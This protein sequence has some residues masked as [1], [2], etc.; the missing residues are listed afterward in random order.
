MVKMICDEQSHRDL[1][2][3][4]DLGSIICLSCGELLAIYQ[5]LRAED[6]IRIL[7]L[8]PGKENSELIAE[9]TNIQLK[10][11]P[12]FNAVSY[13]WADRHGDVSLSRPFSILKSGMKQ[14]LWVTKNCEAALRRFRDL[15]STVYLWIDSICIDQTNVQERSKQVMLMTKIY[16]SA[17]RVLVYLGDGIE[18]A[19]DTLSYCEADA[20]IVKLFDYLRG[21]CCD[22]GLFLCNEAQNYPSTCRTLESLL[23]DEPSHPKSIVRDVKKLLSIR[24]FSRVWI[25]Q[26]IV[27]AREAIIFCGGHSIDWGFLAVRPFLGNN[28]SR[29]EYPRLH[30]VVVP[31]MYLGRQ[32]SQRPA[33]LVDL[34]FTAKRCEASN[35]RDKVF[36]LLGM[37]GLGDKTIRKEGFLLPD[38]SL[39]P[40]VVF[41]MATEYCIHK[42]NDLRILSLIQ[43]PT[44]QSPSWVPNLADTT[45]LPRLADF[46]EESRCQFPSEFEP[47]AIKPRQDLQY[48]HWAKASWMKDRGN[49]RIRVNSH[50]LE[51]EATRVD[52][53]VSGFATNPTSWREFQQW[54]LRKLSVSVINA[55][56]AEY[57][58]NDIYHLWKLLHCT[59]S[60]ADILETA[61][62]GY[63]SDCESEDSDSDG[64]EDE[65]GH[66]FTRL[67]CPHLLK[68]FFWL[69]NNLSPGRKVIFTEGSIGLGPEETQ[70]GDEIWILR[71]AEVPFVLRHQ[72]AL[73]V[74]GDC[75]LMQPPQPEEHGL[76]CADDYQEQCTCE[77]CQ[78][79]WRRL[80]VM[81]K[82]EWETISLV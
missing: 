9:L 59:N 57:A 61:R 37:L 5:P 16:G 4:V 17:Q 50:M 36:A 79:Y 11:R 26:E 66:D 51:V 30:D 76:Y 15:E 1:R 68:Q 34:L 20:H 22:H 55:L 3:A 73:I 75:L 45:C 14:R 25:L 19:E 64:D 72:G 70:A 74:I 41:R 40:E 48:T 78:N 24:W 63:N 29:Q 60:V 39:S 7:E 77:P 62:N 13:T 33:D 58:F 18:F 82:L 35:P 69:L 8:H 2:S 38:Y 6:E 23:N 27:M 67:L 53:V 52:R 31:V 47:L 56:E 32:L 10:E 21:Y 81:D 65:G 54:S 44:G 12:K 43:S 42:S 80:S 28:V 49:W 46:I 71:G